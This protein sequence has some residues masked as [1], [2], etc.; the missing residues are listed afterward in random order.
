MI[1]AVPPVSTVGMVLSDIDIVYVPRYH[2]CGKMLTSKKR[3]YNSS[4]W[5][6]PRKPLEGYQKACF[7]RLGFTF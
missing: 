6:N 1:I 4:D 2:G 7:E 5:K 3:S